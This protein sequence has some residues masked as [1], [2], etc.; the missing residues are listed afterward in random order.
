VTKSRV[1]QIFAVRSGNN[2]HG[3]KPG[4]YQRMAGG[5]VKCLMIFVNKAPEY[6][7]RLPMRELVH[8]DADEIFPKELTKAVVESKNWKRRG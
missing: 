3:L 8:T 2:H 7:V 5:R 1:G 6:R 4:V